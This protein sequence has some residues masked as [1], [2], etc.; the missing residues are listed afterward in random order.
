MAEG[1]VR[2]LVAFRIDTEEFAVDIGSVQ[3]INRVTEVRRIP[4]APP[5]VQGVIN[6]RGKITPVVDLRGIL[7]FAA[8]EADAQSRII[9]V[10]VG[11]AVVGFLVDAVS[12]VVRLPRASI[13]APPSVAGVDPAFVD[14]VGKLDERLLILLD[15]QK[16]FQSPE[17]AKVTSL[18]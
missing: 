2:E 4:N 15:L 3:E 11:G 7:G 1:N 6:L 8:R 12:E 14:G 9:V 5:H 18:G 13:D 17:G 16:M 10:E